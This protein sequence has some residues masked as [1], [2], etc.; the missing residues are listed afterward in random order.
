M[1]SEISVDTE[2]LYVKAKYLTPWG[3]LRYRFATADS[4][5]LTNYVRLNGKESET[6][7]ETHLLWQE[8]GWDGNLKIPVNGVEMVNQGLAMSLFG[9]I[10]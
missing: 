7:D 6:F 2:Q 4:V 9:D 1:I 5:M 10:R 3:V 8:T